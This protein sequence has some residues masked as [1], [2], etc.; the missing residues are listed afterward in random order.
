MIQSSHISKDEIRVRMNVAVLTLIVGGV[1]L[2]IK[3]WAHN[4][5][6]S[7]AVYSDAL[8]SIVN[9]LTAIVGIAV[10]Y[11]ASLPVDQDHP[12]GHGKVEFFS[13]AFEG[14]LITFAAI[15][16]FIEAIK[17]QIANEP[18][19]SLDRGIFLVAVSGVINLL[20]GFVL[21]NFGRKY[22]SPTLS[23]AGVHLL[24]DFWTTVSA[25]VGIALVKITGIFW[26]DRVVAAGL[27]IHMGI[28]G[29]KLVHQSISGLLDAEDLKILQRLAE[30]F[31]KNAGDGIIQIHHAKVI[32]SG[33]F[34]HIDAHVVV[35]EFWTIE[36]A[37][38]RLDVFEN[39]VI[40]EYEYGGEANF[41]LDP[42]KRRYC[43]VCDYAD[44]PVRL[45][46][47]KSRLPVVLEHLRSKT[48]PA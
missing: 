6:G 16:V 41:H 10:I 12:Y 42:C 18:L 32:R 40:G 2:G 23:S 45:E 17:A 9:V 20:F 30:I 21:K 29:V 15:F 25:I 44:C 4:I 48:E 5:T 43:S 37:H 7:Q 1:V 13:S 47:F 35:P 26:I 34:H 36:K 39:N 8:E 22:A 24:I 3:F 11:Y 14:G 33:W 46:P 27:G 28:S 31:E 19:H 38:D